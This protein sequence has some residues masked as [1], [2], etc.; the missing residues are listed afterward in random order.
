M[1]YLVSLG[2][3]VLLSAIVA[4]FDLQRISTH[5][6][7]GV[8]LALAI[9]AWAFMWAGITRGVRGG[10][11]AGMKKVSLEAPT[12]HH[13]ELGLVPIDAVYMVLASV[14]HADRVFLTVQRVGTNKEPPR[15]VHAHFINAPTVGDEFCLTEAGTFDIRP[16]GA[17]FGTA[18]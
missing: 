1:A 5:Q 9:V 11:K 10:I 3:A 17:V 2:F 13:R 7:M 8:V 14:R 16:K 6:L 12:F 4:Y 18:A 15:L